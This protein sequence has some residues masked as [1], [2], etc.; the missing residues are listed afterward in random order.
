MRRD[1][2]RPRNSAKAVASMQVVN[3]LL[4]ALKEQERAL[5][6]YAKGGADHGRHAKAAR[7]LTRELLKSVGTEI[8]EG[9][10]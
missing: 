3:A 7:L 9:K 1:E 5:R 6:F 2:S 10:D 8:H 4:D